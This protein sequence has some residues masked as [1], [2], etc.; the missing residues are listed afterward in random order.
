MYSKLK[1]GLRKISL[2]FFCSRIQWALGADETIRDGQASD[3]V[4][5]MVAYGQPYLVNLFPLCFYFYMSDSNPIRYRW[6]GHRAGFVCA[7]RVFVWLFLSV[8]HN[9]ADMT[10]TNKLFDYGI[11]FHG[12]LYLMAIEYQQYLEGG[13]L[14]IINL[15][16]YLYLQV[17]SGVSK[18][19]TSSRVPWKDC[20]HHHLNGIIA[21]NNFVYNLLWFMILF[22]INR[23]IWTCW[24]KGFL[25][26]VFEFFLI[27]E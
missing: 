26:V 16:V 8:T 24:D 4:I 11:Q 5:P 17:A 2:Y 9:C 19:W 25:Y 22:K 21:N 13:N 15:C 18:L 6:V 20:F 27:P 12:L 7:V 10:N 1:Q 14:V 3:I 23:N